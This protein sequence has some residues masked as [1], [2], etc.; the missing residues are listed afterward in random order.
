MHQLSNRAQLAHCIMMHVLAVLDC[1]SNY[2]Y[3]NH[4]NLIVY[5]PFKHASLSSPCYRLSVRLQA[6]CCSNKLD[7]PGSCNQQYSSMAR[8]CCTA[9][10]KATRQPYHSTQ[11]AAG[12]TALGPVQCV[13]YSTCL[14]EYVPSNKHTV[15]MHACIML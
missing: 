1:T 8:H 4:M 6:H 10:S 13:Q 2:L 14:F 12:D 3:A 11:T 15:S 5:C 9:S 7:I